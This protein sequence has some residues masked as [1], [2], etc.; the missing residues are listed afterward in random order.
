MIGPTCESGSERLPRKATPTY[1]KPGWRRHGLLGLFLCC[2]ASLP[3]SAADPA[4]ECP[5]GATLDLHGKTVGLQYMARAYSSTSFRDMR[6]DKEKRAEQNALLPL[7]VRAELT[8]PAPLRS[9]SVLLPAGTF[10]LAPRMNDLGGWELLVLKDQ[11][12]I[13]LP[14]EVSEGDAEFPYLSMTLTPTVD[15]W[16]ALIVQWGPE[17]Q[18]VVFDKGRS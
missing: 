12:W 9:G 11:E 4:R 1:W 8:T 17:L 15:G 5:A 10:R 14:T 6:R 18:R 13:L 16:F 2:A 3:Q 7:F